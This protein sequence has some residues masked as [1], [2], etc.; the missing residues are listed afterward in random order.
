VKPETLAAISRVSAALIALDDLGADEDIEF[1]A[2]TA[3][4]T[5]ELA[6]RERVRKEA[7]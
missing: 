4:T 3:E 1:L 6:R 7:S 2:D 5:A